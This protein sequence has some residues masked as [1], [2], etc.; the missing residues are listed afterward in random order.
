MLKRQ[1]DSTA[2]GGRGVRI[3]LRSTRLTGSP[4][5]WLPAWQRDVDEQGAAS[6]EVP[7]CFAE[8]HGLGLGT[9]S[10]QQAAEAQPDRALQSNVGA[11]T[12]NA[13]RGTSPL[14]PKKKPG[15][16]GLLEPLGSTWNLLASG[17]RR[18]GMTTWRDFSLLASRTRA[19]ELESRSWITTCSSRR[20]DSASSR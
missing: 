17:Q 4:F 13:P 19:E 6:S 9:E 15:N 2:G 8:G 10:S 11:R 18:S 1:K 20:A 12:W 14:L 5:P 16:A 7:L 3:R